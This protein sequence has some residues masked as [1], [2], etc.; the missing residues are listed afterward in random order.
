MKTVRQRV[1]FIAD[2]MVSLQWITRASE[3]FL[4]K[5]WG[6]KESTVRNYSAEAHRI[7][8][9]D[10]HDR[11]ERRELYTSQMEHLRVLARKDGNIRE[12]RQCT[13]LLCQMQGLFV[14]RHEHSIDSELNRILDVAESTLGKDGARK[15]L[16]AL[17][18][19]KDP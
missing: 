18:K 16:A 19:K 2:M 8:T 7:A 17:S 10:V 9:A 1:H 15:L 4:A 11:G 6:V 12:V 3:R 13:E 5:A 14:T